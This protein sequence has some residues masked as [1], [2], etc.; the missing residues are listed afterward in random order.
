M[1][2][3]LQSLGV[4]KASI[5]RRVLVRINLLFVS[6]GWR[7]K[8]NQKEFLKKIDKVEN[9]KKNNDG[10]RNEDFRKDDGLE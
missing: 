6:Q 8:P 9:F 7:A 10:K 4:M 3:Q 2:Y 5:R 1:E